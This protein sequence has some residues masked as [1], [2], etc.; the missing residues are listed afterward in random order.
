M[1]LPWRKRADDERQH[2][3]K[4]QKRLQEAQADWPRVHA[5]AKRLRD[6]KQSLDQWTAQANR[7]FADRRRT[8]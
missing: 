5:E 1:R 2:R 6:G 4:A 8:R 3:M 7:I